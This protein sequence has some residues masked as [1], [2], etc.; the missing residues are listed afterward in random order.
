MPHS[1]LPLARFLTMPR[2]RPS[3]DAQARDLQSAR[4]TR[5]LAVL[6]FATFEAIRFHWR[7]P[8]QLFGVEAPSPERWTSR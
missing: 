8:C 6:C 3:G 2:G 4:S 7:L 1:T 5:A